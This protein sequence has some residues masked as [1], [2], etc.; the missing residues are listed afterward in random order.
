MLHHFTEY[1][2]LAAETSEGAPTALCVCVCVCVR[3]D[4]LTMLTTN[5]LIVNKEV[6]KE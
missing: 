6:I 4:G 3:A 2:T 1:F 5:I